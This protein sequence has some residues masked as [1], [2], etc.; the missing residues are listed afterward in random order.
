MYVLN[1]SHICFRNGCIC[2]GPSAVLTHLSLQSLYGIFLFLFP[3]D[4]FSI[5]DPVH[6][7]RRF[8]H[9]HIS[10]PAEGSRL[11]SVASSCGGLHCLNCSNGGVSNQN[12]PRSNTV[13]K[14]VL[15]GV[16][17]VTGCAS[18]QSDGTNGARSCFC[19]GDILFGSATNSCGR[20]KG[21]GEQGWIGKMEE[22]LNSIPVASPK[23]EV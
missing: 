11:R 19:H 13:G 16:R 17:H 10:I 1:I 23:S 4:P 5:S 7:G 8:L 20:Y 18:F 9:P 22:F 12:P 3:L 2:C 6:G 21:G 14:F 15:H